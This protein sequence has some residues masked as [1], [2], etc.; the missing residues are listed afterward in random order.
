MKNIKKGYY[1][2]PTVHKNKV[3]FISEDELWLA[4]LTG[5]DAI[6]LSSSLDQLIYPHFSPDGK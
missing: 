6:R 1:R 3:A 4:S 2:Y 5:G